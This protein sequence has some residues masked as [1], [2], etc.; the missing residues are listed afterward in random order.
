[1]HYY[2][3]VSHT[4]NTQK[5]R[6]LVCKT[7]HVLARKAKP[8]KEKYLNKGKGIQHS[9][10]ILKYPYNELKAYRPFFGGEGAESTKYLSSLYN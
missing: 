9:V 10:F 6:Q 2:L 7:E 8:T 5:C 3:V 4:R 1:M